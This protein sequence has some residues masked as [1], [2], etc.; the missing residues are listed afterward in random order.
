MVQG[1]PQT[2]G[3]FES[4]KRM[5]KGPP[6][7]VSSEA[8]YETDPTKDYKRGFSIQTV[9]P[10]PITWAEHVGAQGH[11]GETLTR[12]HARLCPLGDPGRTCCVERTT[13]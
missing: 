10:L 9:S 4:E 11:W 6:P 2:S 13:V 8:F 1:A 12:V 7:E 5:F 3:R